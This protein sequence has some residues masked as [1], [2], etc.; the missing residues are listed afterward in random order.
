MSGTSRSARQCPGGIGSRL[1]PHAAFGPRHVIG[2]DEETIG[3]RTTKTQSKE[4][5]C[6]LTC[7]TD[8]LRTP[9]HLPHSQCLLDAS[10]DALFTVTDDGRVLSWNRG[11]ESMFGFT[12]QEAIGRRITDLTVLDELRGEAS[13]D[14]RCALATGAV[15]VERLRRRKEGALIP[16]SVVMCRAD[17]EP[18]I[19]VCER[20]IT[21]LRR[22]RELEASEAKFRSL[23]ETAPDAIVIVNREGNIT[24]VNAQTEKLFGYSRTELLGQPVEVLIAERIR[25]AHRA[26]RAD[27]FAEPRVRAM[28][29]GLELSGLRKDG[30]EFPIEISLSPLNTEDGPLVSAAIRDISDRKKAEE[31]FK[32]LLDITERKTAELERQKLLR[33]QADL[34]HVN[35]ISLMGE[36]GASLS[37]ELK[38]PVLAAI[39]DANT[40]LHWL[41]RDTPD[42]ERARRAATRVVKGAT[43]A[44]EFIDRLRSFYKKEA[45]SVRA[46]VDVNDVAREMLDLLRSKAAQCSVSL[47]ADLTAEPAFA[48]ADLVQLRQVLMNLILNG[49]EA[50]QESGGELTVTSGVAPDGELTIS[51]SDA[52]CG[53][54]TEH[55]DQIF[56]TF[57]S[58]KPQGSGMG[59]SISRS[60]IESHGGRLW[61]TANEGRGTTF[62]FTVPAATANALQV[63]TPRARADHSALSFL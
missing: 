39:L 59:L 61:A 53:L 15:A 18:L 49:I 60:I 2:Y 38:Q 58:T 6:T 11:A 1:E 9:G 13:T 54:P 12:P 50:M 45:P 26:H 4:Q 62:H 52:G 22:L 20:D 35:R 16:V 40:C 55:S 27:F 23:L 37:H 17:D 25:E 21:V 34:A 28:G 10:P 5:R 41:S 24:I 14:L 32:D 7:M 8:D 51:V 47:R 33:L 36:L 44:G 48:T 57:F 46:I 29:S 42:V 43:L 19:A 31:R 3:F 56:E 30:S 63:A